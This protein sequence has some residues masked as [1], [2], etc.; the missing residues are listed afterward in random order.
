[1]AISPN[2]SS[3]PIIGQI[4]KSGFQLAGLLR[5]GGELRPDQMADIRMLLE[6]RL[7]ELQAKGVILATE[8][9][10][11]LALI[12]G[13]V[14]YDLAP[15]TIDIDG[16]GMILSSTSLGTRTVC[17]QRTYDNY[18]HNSD[19][20]VQGV[21]NQMY[22]EKQAAVTVS[23]YPVP[24]KNMTMD[25]RRIR[26]L[27]DVDSDGVNADL[28]RRGIRLLTLYV[29]E[30][31]CYSGNVPLN[32]I[33]LIRQDVKEAEEKLLGDSHEKLDLQLYI[34]CTRR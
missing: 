31:A 10:T 15:D 27:R 12:A 16:D 23:F 2:F 1:M 6:N 11:T 4:V 30:I 24:N 34:D 19:L 7:K 28:W 33:A 22:I 21:P 26:M 3:N 32:K 29:A 25:Y 14:Q 13:Q 20:T 17:E 9:R 8:E 5:L 18:H